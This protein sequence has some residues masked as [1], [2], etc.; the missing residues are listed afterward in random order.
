MIGILRGAELYRI[1]DVGV[2]QATIT[3]IGVIRCYLDVLV[4][5]WPKELCQLRQ[6]AVVLPSLFSPQS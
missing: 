1:V 2:L 5:L 6:C 4:A 3:A